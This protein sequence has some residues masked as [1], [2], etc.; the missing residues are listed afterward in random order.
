VPNFRLF[1]RHQITIIEEKVTRVKELTEIPNPPEAQSASKSPRPER[2]RK[3]ATTKET[4][5]PAGRGAAR[6]RDSANSMAGKE[7]DAITPA[8]IG[9]SKAGNRTGVRVIADLPGAQN[10]PP[11]TKKKKKRGIQPWV[12]RLCSEPEWEGPWEDEDGHRDAS[13]LA[14]SEPDLPAE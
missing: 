10:G 11:E 4:R 7:S 1:L 12:E 9:K 6:F 5:T 13:K 14:S 3:H 2:G 8:P